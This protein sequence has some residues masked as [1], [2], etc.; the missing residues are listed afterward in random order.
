[1]V[2]QL[3]GELS[4]M[5]LTKMQETAEQYLNKKVKYV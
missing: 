1:M 4:L 2:F 3:A 5:V